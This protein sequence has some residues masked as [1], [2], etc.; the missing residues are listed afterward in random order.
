[1]TDGERRQ[2]G[3]EGTS[4]MG[5]SDQRNTAGIMIFKQKA[6][7]RRQHRLREGAPIALGAA[8]A[9]KGACGWDG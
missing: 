1:M 3:K 9:Q 6:I 2:R 4:P 7:K 8:A 5:L